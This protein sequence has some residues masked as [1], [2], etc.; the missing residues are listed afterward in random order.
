M[1]VRPTRTVH[2]AMLLRLLALALLPSASP[3]VF[4]GEPLGSAPGAEL[5]PGPDRAANVLVVVVDD[6]GWT[7]FS[8]R[9]DPDLA[10]SA[11]D[12]HRTPNVERLAEDGALFTRAYAPA[13]M[14]TPS[15]AA[16]LTGL[17]PA[18]LH[19]TTPGGGRSRSEG[20]LRTPTPVKD[21]PTDVDTLAEVLSEAGL[22]CAHL[23][24]WHVGSAGPGEHGFDVHDGATA[25]AAAAAA[26]AGDGEDPK[27]VVDLTDRALVFMA[28]CV[29]REQ[30]FY[31]HL[32]HY[33]VHGPHGATP[34]SQEAVAPWTT[35][36]RHRDTTYAAMVRDVDVSLG[37]LLDALD[38]LGVADDTLVILTSDNGAAS[39]ARRPH[40]APLSGG[41]GELTEG[42]LRVPLIV[43][44]PGVDA[45]AAIDAPVIG[46]DLFPT[47]GASLGLRSRDDL[48]GVSL[49]PL[50]T[51]EDDAVE[52][53]HDAL[54]FHYPHYSSNGRKTPHSAV[55]VGRHKLL[56]DDVAGRDLLF[57][58]EADIGET[59]DLS[60]E[61][62]ELAREL[63]EVLDA[64]LEDADAQLVR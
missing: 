23:G 39:R 34:A 49:L 12:Y 3:L 41:K 10:E 31:L 44:G 35:G 52:R 8:Q 20:A 38:E 53:P 46:T 22:R 33:A 58:L 45:G 50:L 28:E 29:E 13:P 42:G 32:S 47:I 24:K 51:G 18:R 40:N 30:P 56:R 59:R 60:E 15:R 6:L 54:L 48:D 2:A 17:S 37:R 5:E 9:S 55:I 26:A 11:S 63:G 27:Q 25:N 36:S 21:L 57:D 61:E 16:I 4:E 64:L 14:C 62:P 1:R 7:D 43:R 19:M